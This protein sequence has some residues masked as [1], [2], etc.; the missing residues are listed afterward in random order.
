MGKVFRRQHGL[1]SER[2]VWKPEGSSKLHEWSFHDDLWYSCWRKGRV[3]EL[4]IYQGEVSLF[5]KILGTIAIATNPASGLYS[6]NPI[7]R[8]W[9]RPIH[10]MNLN[11]PGRPTSLGR[12]ASNDGK[13]YCR[14][15]AGKVSDSLL[16]WENRTD[17]FWLLW[18]QAFVTERLKRSQSVINRYAKRVAWRDGDYRL[19]EELSVL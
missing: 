15:L 5:K 4:I 13:N 8:S 10:D 14:P 7:A 6:E 9:F 11:S 18:C 12:V 1:E 17:I 16:A 3:V 19:S 2:M